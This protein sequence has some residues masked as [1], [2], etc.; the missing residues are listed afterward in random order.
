MSISVSAMALPGSPRLCTNCLPKFRAKEQNPHLE[1]S[2]LLDSEKEKFGY[3]TG[4]RV[5][6]YMMQ[7]VYSRDRE[8]VNVKTILLENSHIRATFLPEYGMR[9]ISLYQKDLHRELLFRNPVLQFANL[10]IRDAWFSGGIEWNVAQMGHTFTTCDH[11]YAA[12]C[13][14]ESGTEFLRCY[15]YERCKGIYWQIDFH[16]GEDDRELTA[17][18]RFINPREEP[19][20]FYWWTNIA[21]PEKTARVFS[22]NED[23]IYI[24]TTSLT[25]ETAV[26]GMCHGKM[27]YLSSLPGKDV[28]YPEEF[29]YSSE[30]FF[31]N[32]R[33]VEQTWEAVT[34]E[35]GSAFYE[36][37]S[38]RLQYRKMFCW[39]S[40]YGGMHWKDFLSEDGKGAYVELQAGLAPTQVHGL[41]FPEKTTWDF[42]Q[43]FGG[44]N[45]NPAKT[46]GT[47]QISQQYIQ[48]QVRRQ[49]ST[50]EIHKRLESCRK[51]ADRPVKELLHLGSG[52]GA[53]EELRCPGITPAGLSFP[54]AAIGP[55]EA[56]WLRLLRE[57]CIADREILNFP[58]S[59]LVDTRYEEY[60]REAAENGGYTAMN[61]YGVMCYEDSRYDEGIRWF[62]KSVAAR[63]N[64]L[65]YRNLFCAY[66][67][68]DPKYAIACMEKA[69]ALQG[70][71]PDRA[72]VEEY[73]AYLDQKGYHEKLWNYYLSLPKALR[74]VERIILN[75]IPAAVSMKAMDF[76]ETQ[77]RKEF[78]NIREG[79]RA[80]TECYFTYQAL[81]EARDTG[82]EFNDALVKKYVERNVIPRNLDFRLSKT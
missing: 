46:R 8:T 5:L 66:G 69:I 79:E 43:I 48:Q 6:P 22:G 21:V 31:Q 45:V 74:E 76:L 51:A 24:D 15:E 32:R 1:S 29:D 35:D 71:C 67:D 26:K 53:L 12:R 68:S 37:S 40:H 50:E 20:P 41:D 7:D 75:V 25:S 23:V 72:F 57:R 70:E 58:E 52:F 14:D 73:T 49:I 82:T 64:P 11:L 54:E 9:L 10:A 55:Q 13:R 19:V 61:Y 78:V 56:T 80:F 42:V 3:Q 63:P 62:E 4:T 27:P 39:G 38:E 81:K 17:Y 60:L 65:A 28:S 44:M 47:W 2:K 77:F 34:Y 18:V 16:L 59:Y 30:Y 36:C 33:D